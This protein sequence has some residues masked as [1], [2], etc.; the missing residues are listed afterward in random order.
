M[1]HQMSLFPSRDRPEDK[2]SLQGGELNALDEMFAASQRFR[3]SLEYMDLLRFMARFPKYSAFNCVLLYTQSPELSYVATAGVWRNQ[4]K[5]RL[6]YDARPLVILAPMSPVRFVY[7]IKDTEGEAVPPALLRPTATTDMLPK[8]VYERTVHNCVFHG[9]MVR[10][11]VLAKKP[12]EGAIHLT[13][14]IRRQYKGLELDSQTNYLIL[15]NTAHRP[16]DKYAALVY[17]L[18]RIFCGHK[19]VDGS[20]WWLDRQ[21]VKP[22]VKEIEVESVVFLVCRR[23]GLLKNAEKYLSACRT[24]DQELPVLGLSSILQATNYIENMGKSVWKKPGKIR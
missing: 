8:D 11:I 1:S 15:L 16:E 2:S 10:E 18:G 20:A 21:R 12:H 9:I 14:D 6:K 3:S 7:D 13:E 5:R 17:E 19:G 24:K 22:E 4:F 23:I